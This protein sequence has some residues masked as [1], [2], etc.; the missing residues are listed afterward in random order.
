M[1]ARAGSRARAAMAAAKR[2]ECPSVSPTSTLEPFTSTCNTRAPTRPTEMA[3]A[4]AAT[5]GKSPPDQ[6]E[7]PA[8]SGGKARPI[9]A[10]SRRVRR[11]HDSVTEAAAQHRQGAIA[12]IPPGMLAR[13]RSSGECRGH[14]GTPTPRAIA[15][16]R[17]QRER[18]AHVP[19]AND[20]NVHACHEYC[21]APQGCSDG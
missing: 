17:I 9:R 7:K 11:V 10:T 12:S 18:S 19:R 8:R 15:G 16:Q 20:E 1:S 14:A 13:G 4:A 3:A 5:A 2:G 21:R 6:G